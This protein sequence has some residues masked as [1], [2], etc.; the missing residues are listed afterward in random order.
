M[1]DAARI[2]FVVRNPPN[3]LV[4]AIWCR[5]AARLRGQTITFAALTS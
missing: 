1:A 5:S 4:T 3:G 2:A